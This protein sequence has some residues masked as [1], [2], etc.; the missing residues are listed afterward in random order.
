MPLVFHKTTGRW[1]HSGKRTQ[2]WRSRVMGSS[3]TLAKNSCKRSLTRRTTASRGEF[4]NSMTLIQRELTGIKL[5]RL[6]C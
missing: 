2:G 6:L 1:T 3:M 5:W 4:S